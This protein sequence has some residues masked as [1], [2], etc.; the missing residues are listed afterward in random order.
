M[1]TD[2]APCGS[3]TSSRSDK[4]LLRDEL[5]ATQ[6]FLA[7]VLRSIRDALI[8][9]DRSAT[10]QAVNQAAL[11]LVG[12]E[13]QELLGAPLSFVLE[14][15]E[16]FGQDQADPDQ[17]KRLFDRLPTLAPEQTYLAK[18]GS[19]LPVYFSTTPV[20]APDG[21]VSALICTVLATPERAR[22]EIELRQADKLE[23]VGRLAAGI[24][25]EINTPVQFVG[26]SVYFLRSVFGDLEILLATYRSMCSELKECGIHDDLLRRVGRAEQEAD[27]PYL[28]EQ[29][30]KACER[31]IEGVARVATIVRALKRFAHPPDNNRAPADINQALRDTLAVARNEYKYVAEVET[32]LAPLPLLDCHISDLNQVFLNLIVNAAHAVQDV[33][34]GTGKLGR[35]VVRSF[36][37]GHRIVVSI[38]D[39]G[40]GIPEEIHTRVFDPFFTTKPAGHG[41]GQGLAIARHIVVDRHGG[42]LSFETEAGKG[43]TF[44]VGLPSDGSVLGVEA[45]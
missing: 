29:I 15:P 23:S 12:F 39:T 33:V 16:G 14:I 26:D 4:G 5:L 22:A 6:Q 27:L 25:H 17:A 3:R 38:S 37:E 7:A 44:R 34:E 1:P 21:Q 11:E 32:D 41:T 10:V 36:V 45:A 31:M 40:T 35:I 42:R 2:S 20:L 18:D 9:V 30:P 8:M 13:E 43:T 24:A 28:T 19:K